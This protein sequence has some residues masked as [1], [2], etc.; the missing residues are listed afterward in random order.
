MN[1]VFAVADTYII[2]GL[3][4]AVLLPLALVAAWLERRQEEAEFTRKIVWYR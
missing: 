2:L 1:I 4:A 3:F